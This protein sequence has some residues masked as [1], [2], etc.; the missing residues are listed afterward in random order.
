MI[1]TPELPRDVHYEAIVEGS[2]VEWRYT[3]TRSV[4]EHFLAAFD[5]RSPVHVDEAYARARGFDDVVVHGAILNGF[6]S[7]FV[8]MRFPGRRALLLSADMRYANPSFI[9]DEITL[10]ARVTQKVDV[11]RVIVLTVRLLNT[12]RGTTAATGR[13]Q[14]SVADH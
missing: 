5:D 8:G 14:V 10:I 13:V 12:T 7:H 4:Y 11:Q 2:E 6:V 3:L 1:G 9:G